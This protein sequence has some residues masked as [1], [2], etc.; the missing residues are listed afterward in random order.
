MS[1][2]KNAKFLSFF[3]F[4]LVQSSSISETP[5][6]L[7]SFPGLESEPWIFCFSIFFLTLIHE[8]TTALNFAIKLCSKSVFLT[9]SLLSTGAVAYPSVEHLKRLRLRIGCSLTHKDWAS[10]ERPAKN[11][12]S[13]LLGL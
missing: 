6:Y 11:K 3:Y 2:C 12:R 13:C 5:T 10:P 7:Q 8:V 9:F 4:L 1:K